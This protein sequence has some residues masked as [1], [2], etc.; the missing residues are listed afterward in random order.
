MKDSKLNRRDFTRRSM[1]A[2]TGLALWPSTGLKAVTKQQSSSARQPENLK[3]SLN[4]YSFNIPLR[5]GKM[6]LGDLLDFCAQTG[7]EGVDITG[8]YFPG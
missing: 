3:I 2:V 5:E 8:Y 1:L 7:F 6:T 4:A